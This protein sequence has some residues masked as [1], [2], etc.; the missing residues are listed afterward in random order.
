MNDN[1]NLHVYYTNIEMIKYYVNT[2]KKGISI[3]TGTFYW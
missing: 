1:I 2:G 3:F